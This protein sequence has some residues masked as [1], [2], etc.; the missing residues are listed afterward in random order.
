MLIDL[1]LRDRLVEIFVE[2]KRPQLFGILAREV[3]RGE[4]LV[5]QPVGEKARGV[6][7]RHRPVL[8][9]CGDDLVVEL[10]V[11]RLLN[12][13]RDLARIFRAELFE[14]VIEDFAE[15]HGVFRIETAEG[16]QIAFAVGARSIAADEG[17]N[18][19]QTRGE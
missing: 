17:K 18:L 2:K 15:G 14:L 9:L 3:F 7:G 4:R 6:E 8:A 5:F 16:A 10:G 19:A 11:A 12:Q 13:F 1:N